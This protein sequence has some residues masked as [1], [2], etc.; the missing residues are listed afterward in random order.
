MKQ[1]EKDIR[2]ILTTQHTQGE[3]LRRVEKITE[4]TRKQATATNGRV[5]KLEERN[6]LMDRKK[7]S[8][9][10]EWSEGWLFLIGS[11]ALIVAY[12]I[13]HFYL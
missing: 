12:T 5:T 1:I 3:I 13:Q 8:G 2:Q 11:M 4:E 9:G 6:R 10:W 7:K